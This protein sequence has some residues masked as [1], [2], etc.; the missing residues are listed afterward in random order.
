MTTNDMDAI[1]SPL[2]KTYFELDAKGFATFQDMLDNPPAPM[3]SLRRILAAQAPWGATCAAMGNTGPQRA[4]IGQLT[5]GQVVHGT[6]AL[7]V[8]SLELIADRRQPLER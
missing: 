8:G 5:C 4:V 3:E 1:A 2:D 7:A 6:P